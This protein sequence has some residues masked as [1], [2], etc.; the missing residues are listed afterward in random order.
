MI[1]ELEQLRREVQVYE[2][3]AERLFVLAQ[4]TNN[5]DL[6][7]ILEQLN[8]H[9][10]AAG[11]PNKT[12]IRSEVDRLCQDIEVICVFNFSFMP[13]IVFNR[14]HRECYGAYIK[15]RK[16]LGIGIGPTSI[17]ALQDLRKKM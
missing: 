12:L 9:L 1:T 2:S 11:R 10:I 3:I 17:L 5:K 8:H 7:G 14:K 4:S 16:D 15:S 6:N 13:T